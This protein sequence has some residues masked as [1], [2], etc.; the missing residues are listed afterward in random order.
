MAKIEGMSIGLGDMERINADTL[1][2]FALGRGDTIVD[3]LTD[4]STKLEP[5]G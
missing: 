3:A 1:T 2:A 5:A 4:L